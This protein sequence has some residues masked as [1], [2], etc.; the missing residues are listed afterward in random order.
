MKPITLGFTAAAAGLVV[1]VGAASIADSLKPKYGII[2]RATNQDIDAQKWGKIKEKL[3]LPPTIAGADSREMLYRVREFN[4]GTPVGNTD[5]G[6]LPE[7]ELLEDRRVPTN[8]TGHAFQIGVG[9]RERS[10]TIPKSGPGMPQS[11]SRLNLQES[12]KMV[13]DVDGVLDGN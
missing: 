10:K 12:K 4:N 7:A 13:E 2:L 5:E 8:F 3:N 11:H 9:A 1:G 6:S